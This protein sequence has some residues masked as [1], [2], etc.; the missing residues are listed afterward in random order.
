MRK[1]ALPLVLFVAFFCGCGDNGT[2]PPA[3][4]SVSVSPGTVQ[5]NGGET[6][7]FTATVTNTTNTAVTWSVTGGG[8]ISSSGLYTAPTLIASQASATVTATA[9]ADPSKSA[10]GTVTL[11]PIAVSVSPLNPGVDVVA[12]QQFTATVTG[13]SDTRVTWGISGAGCSGSECGAIDSTGLYTAPWCVPSPATV[14]VTA[15]SVAD[16]TKASAATVTTALA[17][18][19]LNGQYAFL[20]QGTDTDGLM[21]AA[22]TLIA[23]G[24]GNVTSGLEDVVRVGGA[25]TNV[26]F[27][28]TYSSSCYSRGTLTLNDSLSHTTSFAYALNAAGDRARYI[29]LDNT[30]D[31]GAGLL[32]KQQ[33]SAFDLSQTAGDFAFGYSGSTSTMER[34][35]MIGQFTANGAGAISAGHLDVN[36]GGV[37]SANSTLSGSYTLSSLTGRGTAVFTAVPP[38]SN[39]PAP[40][41]APSAAGPPPSTTYHLSFYVVSA[42]EAFWMS[43]DSPGATTPFFGGRVLRQSGG[44]FALSSLNAP[45]VFHLTGETNGSLQNADVAVGIVSPDGSGNLTG[46]PMDENYDTVVSNYSS[47]TG[48]Y[49]LDG[50]GM[51]RGTIHLDM[52]GGTTRDLTFYL[53]SPNIAFL[54]DGTATVAGPSVGVG[55]WEPRTG[56][57]YSTASFAGTYYFGT[58]GLAT[59]YVPVLSGVAIADG[60]GHLGGMGDESDIFGNYAD[61]TVFVGSYQVPATGRIAFGPLLFYMIS[62]ERGVVFEADDSQHQPSI[63]MIEQ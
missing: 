33:T 30:G 29:Q 35:G 4:I 13:T 62:P 59:Q 27:T 26:T 50:G 21:Q 51:G 61:I 36:I 45:A 2:T 9:Q 20:F 52:G 25:S 14:T 15:T 22:G 10:G 43:V 41:T 56:E 37:T 38:L 63:I 8:A 23:D 17:G 42:D 5:L 11:V 31:R 16:P 57:P 55:F 47:L 58:F 1:S 24:N 6:Q 60:A 3:V 44:P 7:Q 54:M 39:P 48:T 53:V 12:T 28:G 46:G 40:G 19:Q 34:V 18:P 49:A 32:A